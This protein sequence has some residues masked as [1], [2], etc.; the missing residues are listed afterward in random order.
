METRHGAQFEQA[1]AV[2]K[3]GDVGDT[4]NLE[5]CESGQVEVRLGEQTAGGKGFGE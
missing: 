5:V 1:G 3:H 2:V 4:G